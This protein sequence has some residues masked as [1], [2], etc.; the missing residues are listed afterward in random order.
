MNSIFVHWKSTVAGLLGVSL[1]TTAALLA[2]PNI[3]TLVS[4]KTL[5]IMGAFQAVG[6]VWIGI[7]TQDA[8][9]VNK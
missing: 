9:K 7:I 6:R 5:L 8:D 3:Q 2:L 4:A 1:P